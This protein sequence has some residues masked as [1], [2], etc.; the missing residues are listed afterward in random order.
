[1]KKNE[2]C[3][4]RSFWCSFFPAQPAAGPDVTACDDPKADEEI[5]VLKVKQPIYWWKN[6]KL[7]AALTKGGSPTEMHYI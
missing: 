5:E 2:P 1:M 3:G 4:L 6:R 7:Q